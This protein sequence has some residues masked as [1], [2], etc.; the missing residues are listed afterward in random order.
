MRPSSSTPLRILGQFCWTLILF[1]YTDFKTIVIPVTI[2]ASVAA[3]V[4][5][6]QRLFAGILWTWLNLLQVG[7]SNQYQS[8]AEDSINRPW[9][10][11][12]GGRISHNSAAILRWLLVPICVLSSIPFGNEVVLSSL[13]LTGLL[14][15]HDEFG[16]DKHW[17][18]KNF[19]N[20]FG[21]LSFEL[22]A[23]QIM[24]DYF[25]SLLHTYVQCLLDLN[26]RLDHI[27]VQSLIFNGFVVLTTI[28]SQDFSDVQGDAA[29]G[30]KTFPI[31]APILSRILTP[32]MLILWSVF[33]GQLWKLGPASHY[34]L[35][36]LGSTVGWRFF[37]FR[38]PSYDAN[39]FVAYNVCLATCH[40]PFT[41]SCE[42]G[43]VELLVPSVNTSLG[44]LTTMNAF[45][46][47]VVCG[48]VIST[49]NFV[50]NR[51]PL[52]KV[53][54]PWLAAR[55]R[56]YKAY[57]DLIRDGGFLRHLDWLHK[58]YG[59]VVRVGP[60][61]VHFSDPTALEIIYGHRS[62][63]VKDPIVYGAFM[64]DLSSFGFRDPHEA[65]KRREMLN[66]LFSRR[67]TLKLEHA[68]QA[69]V[70]KLV[71]RVLSYEGGPACN[72]FMA[73][74]SATLDIITSYCFAKS[75]DTLDDPG[76]Q[77]AIVRAILSGVSIIW[78]FKYFPALY[79]IAD[80]MPGWLMHRISPVS[81]GYTDLFAFLSQHLDRILADPSALDAADHETI[82]HHLLNPK[83]EKHDIPSKKSLLDESLTLLGAGSETVGNIVTTGV[84]R[85]LSDQRILGKL[86][87]ELDRAW[88]EISNNMS[89][90][91]LEK[92][93]Y[94]TAVIKESIRVA[95][96]VVS[97]VPRVVGPSDVYISDY[98]VPAGTVVS[99]GIT[100]IHENPEIFE[101]PKTFWPERWLEGEASKD[102]ESKFFV[103]FSKGPRMCLGI[104]LAWCELYLLFGNMFR[105]IDMEIHNTGVED[106]DFQEHWLPVFR[107]RE[108]HAHV[109][110]R[111]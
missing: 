43:R 72:L 22:G 54:G 4:Q 2:F 14:I 75:F 27:A 35:C 67:A 56:W 41:C 23:T 94:L 99:I 80:R 26:S 12:P 100:F 24:S 29:F 83:L 106:F 58:Q 101:M 57:F 65:R 25:H 33:L 46:I 6:T 49:G 95:H 104:N 86:R 90:Q 17:A 92:L 69:K 3:P 55:T 66:P 32:F 64:Q 62:N 98:H 52:K 107:K 39:T 1:T 36:G 77:H 108:F 87:T 28:H 103:P 5:S 51:G 59:P 44:I 85:V 111:K 15:A 74:R 30:R 16:W 89:Y 102:V 105:K 40:T 81:K 76:F 82:Y 96:G 9:R 84:F 48:V 10:P 8:I 61:E 109:R 79:F 19:I 42:M 53:P 31:Y 68:I 63:F 7:V 97:P 38:T 20:A 70:D 18:G 13:T 110:S 45:W 73:F 60:S 37:R 50:Y 21:Y 91:A 88:P 78:T 34:L 47:W 93:P 71:D 11:L